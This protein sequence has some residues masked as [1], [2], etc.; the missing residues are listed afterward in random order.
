M[1]LLVR[2]WGV[3]GVAQN[4]LQLSSRRGT[5]GPQGIS[6][7]SWE[8]G[9]IHHRPDTTPQGSKGTFVESTMSTGYSEDMQ[10]D[11]MTKD[12]IK[13]KNKKEKKDQK[14]KKVKWKG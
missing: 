10:E 3:I 14:E 6:L 13:Q 5:L 2:T 7:L 1:K 12:K 4:V 9:M 8:A 11:K